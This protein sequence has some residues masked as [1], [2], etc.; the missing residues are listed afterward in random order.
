M[1]PRFDD[2]LQTL[3]W[4][5]TFGLVLAVWMIFV[6]LWDRRQGQS[7]RRVRSRLAEPAA[8][9]GRELR[10]WHGGGEA[11]L[12]VPGGPRRAT[13]AERMRRIGLDAGWRSPARQVFL[14]A[15]IGALVLSLVVY[16]LSARLAPAAMAAAAVL[17]GFWLITQ[18]R[19]VDRTTLF[20]RQ[21][22]DALELCARALRSGHPLSGCFQLI[23]RE[24]P[25][26]V[27]TIFTEICQQQALGS[28]LDEALRRAAELTQSADMKLFAASLSIHVRTGGNLAGVMENLAL[29]IRERMRQNRRFRVITAQTQFSKRVLLAMPFLVFGALSAISPEY[30]RPLYTTSPGMLLLA[31]AVALMLAGWF[32]MERMAAVR[33]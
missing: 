13:L 10:L 29:V 4:F 25:A 7:R 23:S 6:L 17:F 28:S 18:R 14:G 30:V 1:W 20:E 21:L 8:A 16:F 19:I 9:G 27:G 26:P 11:T 24:I 2:P 3:T 31:L 32:L 22:V 15:G 33:G 5:S 12:V